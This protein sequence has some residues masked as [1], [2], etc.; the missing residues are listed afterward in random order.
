[1]RERFLQT[2][3]GEETDGRPVWLMRQAGRYLPEYRALRARHSFEELGR[4]AELSAEVTLM[5]LARFDLDA[6]VIFAD[7]M[8][9]VAALGVDVRFDPG[10]VVD[11]PVRDAASFARLARP[12]GAIAPVVAEVIRKTRASLGDRAAVLGFAGAP[13]SIAAYLVE[14]QGRKGFPAVRSLARSAPE[15]LDAL[16]ERLV[17]LVARYLREQVA[18]GA[19]AVQIFDTWSG[20]LDEAGWRER[21]RPHLVS[22]FEQTADLGVPRI[23]FLQDA[24]HLVAAAAAL[25][26]DALSVDWRVDL[27]ALRRRIGPKLA[28]QG[29]VDPSVLLA[30]PAATRAAVSA[31]LEAM[32]AKGH[33]VNLGHGILPETPVESVA[34]MVETVRA[35]ARPRRRGSPSPESRP[36]ANGGGNGRARP[37]AREVTADLL[38]TYDREGPRYTS[39]PTAVEFHDGVDSAVYEKLLARANE[40]Q[41]QPLS[42]YVHLPFCEERCLYCGCH[43]I[44]TPHMDRAEPYLDLL[45]REIDL[46]AE[47]LPN[48][49]EVSQ[50]HLGGGTPTFF[51][52]DQLND[53]LAHWHSLFTPT[54]GAEL[55]VEVDPRVTTPAHLDVLADH[56]FNRVSMG[57]QDFTPEVQRAIGRIQSAELTGALIEHA[58][59]AGY[60]GINVDLI[61]GLPHQRPETFERTVD[62]V[63]A[64]GVDRAAVYSFA[65]LPTMKTHHQKID[66]ADL[67]DRETKFALFA[68]A[69]ERFLA[70]GYEAIGMD[71]FAR[72]EDELAK[73]RRAHRLRRNFQGY[74]VIPA[75]D[76]VGLG[77][78]GIGDVRGA[79]VQNEKKLSEYRDMVGAGRLP[80]MRG[81][82]RTRDDEIRSWVIHELMCNARVEVREVEERFALEFASYFAEDLRRLR[83]PE[84]EALVT[85][86]D[87]RIEAT[88]VGELFLRNLAMCFDRFWREKHEKSEKPVFSRTV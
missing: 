14:G 28:L 54:K 80:V 70:A 75:P 12:E 66:E 71:H 19:D 5:P 76:V 47:R 49:R 9:P 81:V 31:L 4:S 27:P 77:I 17:D 7:L 86:G 63:I 82:V 88:P 26:V 59:S 65:Y 64:M 87:Q 15:L 43:V 48:R 25:P 42:M 72:P 73:A 22:L 24:P 57:V 44:I 40:L 1:M 30:G 61:Y 85:V 46:V 62:T 50:L 11:H 58:R 55:A 18:A 21:V 67:P 23:F 52:P 69:R 6:A 36:G 8:T 60:S 10:P 37:V 56:G 84:N 74:T 68:V 45:A 78:S 33:V 13:W 3:A 20:L 16:Q 39:Y 34:A 38:L 32:P 51:R 41:G 53:L 79:Y 2:L 35:E 29:N 83:A